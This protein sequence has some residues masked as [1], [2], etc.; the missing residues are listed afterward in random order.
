MKTTILNKNMKNIEVFTKNFSRQTYP[1]RKAGK[2]KYK[3]W[4]LS[5][6]QLFLLS[7]SKARKKK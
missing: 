4:N 6:Q 2:A 7:E 3:G 1:D 5:S